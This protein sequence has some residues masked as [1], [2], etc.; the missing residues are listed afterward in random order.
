MI[1]KL[2][3][4]TWISLIFLLFVCASQSQ[5]EDMLTL[6]VK[7]P[8]NYSAKD[9]V[10]VVGSF[11]D[12]VLGEADTYQLKMKNGLL[13]AQIPIHEKNVF[14]TFL[15]NKDWKSMPANEMGKSE[16]LYR[17]QANGRSNNIK[18][19]IALWKGEAPLVKAGHTLAG[20]I[21][22]HENVDMPQLS[23]SGNISVYLPKSY[24]QNP[25]RS[26]PVLYMLDGQNIF[27]A[28]SA[29]NDEW[30]IDELLEKL[31]PQGRLEEIIVV[32][33]PNSEQRQVEYNPWP[34][35]GNDG[36]EIQGKG[37]LT[38]GFIKNTLKPFIDK[39]YRT[40]ASTAA[41]G[42]A[43]SSL[44]GLMALYA[45]LQ[46]SDAFGFVAAFSPALSIE[47]M[48][49]A[50]VLFAAI[51]QKTYTGNTKIYFDMG[52]VEYG[53]Y[54]RIEQLQSL[55]LKQGFAPANIRMVKDDI[56]RHCEVDWS[57]R[58]PDALFWLTSSPEA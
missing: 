36:K 43:G 48:A 45:A 24:Q 6:Q 26:Y 51:Q 44:G 11:N 1:I 27:D 38:I 46:H 16:C 31:T 58:F 50:N 37:E 13:T 40:Q 57:R 34:F 19:N 32:S 55:L 42:L 9:S 3:A 10:H 22:Q 17:Y 29:Y 53:N 35:K 23:R 41:T 52:L 39:T 8:A 14:F 21:R 12:W 2:K 18:L 15:K 7:P 54:D 56:G 5:A 49:G 47:N 4:T 20:N 28:Y 30:Q 25:D 33:V